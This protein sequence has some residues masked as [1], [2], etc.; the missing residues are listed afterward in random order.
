MKF[1]IYYATVFIIAA[2][3]YIVA[4]KAKAHMKKSICY[5]CYFFLFLLVLFWV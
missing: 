5:F 3:T 1:A 4:D 2:I